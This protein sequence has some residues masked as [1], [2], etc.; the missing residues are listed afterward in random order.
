MSK[1]K[2]FLDVDD[3]LISECFPI[4]YDLR[5]GVI[6]QLTILGKLFDC[7]WLTHRSE[8][9]LIVTFDGLFA[10]RMMRSF[11]YANW[12]EVNNKDKAP[13]VISQG[14]DLFW[15]EDPL[16]TGDLT[17]LYDAGLSDRYIEVDPKGL[18][19]FTRAL[20]VLF[21]RAGIDDAQIKKSGGFP[22]WFKEPLGI[23]FEWTF[24]K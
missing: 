9:D 14:K 13:Y 24:Y 22:S 1:T 6:T 18:W 12:R 2:L 17:E 5:P 16:S 10:N 3:T 23:A 11:Q 8:E 7:Y 19:G 4:G 20:R 15:V 21:E